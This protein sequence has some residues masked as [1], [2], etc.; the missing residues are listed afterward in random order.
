M[1]T[2]C[3]PTPGETTGQNSPHADA[4]ASI[5]FN[6]RCKIIKK[7]QTVDSS[8][9]SDND[10]VDVKY[11]NKK[12]RSIYTRCGRWVN[13]EVQGFEFNKLRVYSRDYYNKFR[14]MALALGKIYEDDNIMNAN[15]AGLIKSRLAIE[16]DK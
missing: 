9:E 5:F 7:E 6:N 16:K 14:H 11:K 1:R 8:G 2:S 4:S 3:S 10:S 15:E 13:K 12:V